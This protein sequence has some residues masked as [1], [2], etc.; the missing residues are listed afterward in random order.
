MDQ[1]SKDQDQAKRFIEAAREL[2][3][4]ESEERFES[5]L[6]SIARHK[7]K[8]EEGKGKKPTKKP[9]Q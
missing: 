9:G 3:C 8:P 1:K 2:A 5:A 6:R 7:P 4:D